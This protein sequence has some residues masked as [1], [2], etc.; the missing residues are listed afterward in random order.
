MRPKGCA[1]D[2]CLDAGRLWK[3]RPE[4]R[5]AADVDGCGRRNPVSKRKLETTAFK[6]LDEIN[7]VS[8]TENTVAGGPQPVPQ[9]NQ[10]GEA[11]SAWSLQVHSSSHPGKPSDKWS[12]TR[13]RELL[14]RPLA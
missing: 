9:L 14:G 3:R 11:T 10:T 12:Q 7:V 2:G 4:R 8:T 13:H 6:L 5:G 1:A